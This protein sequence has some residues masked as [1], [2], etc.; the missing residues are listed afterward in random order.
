MFG[1]EHPNR[2]HSLEISVCPSIFGVHAQVE[3]SKSNGTTSS[4]VIETFTG[5]CTQ[6]QL[7]ETKTK[8]SPS[9]RWECG[10]PFS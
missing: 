5:A 9:F 2:V 6:A 1:P 7:G 3:N 4:N 8:L 10:S